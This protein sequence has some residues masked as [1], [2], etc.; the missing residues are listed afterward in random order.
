MED[1]RKISKKHS[2]VFSKNTCKDLLQQKDHPILKDRQPHLKAQ[3]AV[4]V[5]TRRQRPKS[6]SSLSSRQKSG[7][8]G[9]HSMCDAICVSFT[10]ADST[11]A[12][13]YAK[14]ANEDFTAVQLTFSIKGSKTDSR[15]CKE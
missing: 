13:R 12:H 8:E 11:I 2:G 5:F 4:N 1:L 9:H 6:N 3:S 15:A 7:N 10:L 14:S